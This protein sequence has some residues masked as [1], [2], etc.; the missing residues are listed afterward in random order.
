MKS[1][2]EWM[3]VRQ[4]YEAGASI[5]SIAR[6]MGMDRKTVRKHLSSEAPPSFSPRHAIL[7]PY[8]DY[9]VTRL[10]QYPLSAVRIHEDIAAMGYSGGYTQVKEFMR[11]VRR[12]RPVQ[13][14]IR[15]E[16]PPGE[17]AQADW[18]DFSSRQLGEEVVHLFAFVMVLGYS[19]MRFVEFTTS[20]DTPTFIKCHLHA[21]EHFGGWPRTILYDNSKNV[22][23][24]RALRTPDS[25]LNSL[26]LDF[27]QHHGI[28]PRLCKPGIAG[29]K[30]KGKV[31][32][33][34]QYVEDNFFLGREF[35]SLDELNSSAWEWCEKANAK[36]HGT[37]HEVP[38]ERLKLEGL[39]G[40]AS[41]VPYQ[42]VRREVRKV[43]RDCFLSYRGNRYSVPWQHAGRECRLAIYDDFFDVFVDEVAVARHGIVPG[44]H[45]CIA[46]KE[47]FEG[48]YGQKRKENELRHRARLD[49]GTEG[50]VLVPQP[51]EVA[52]RDLSCYERF[53]GGEDD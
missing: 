29:A 38:M 25:K 17:Q 31:E 34:I 18:I 39:K 46:R 35:G 40:V 26:Y 28:K 21:F 22:V 27:I 7:D 5:S 37:T 12:D 51:V 2:V 50:L 36:V 10:S 53:S 52:K 43:S 13:A 32:R 47:H 48:L 14:E 45:R 9:I 49:C 44:S 42:V 4:M 3:D 33:A 8:K 15:F 41:I 19:R 20:V 11:T 1:E 24:V 16:T 6:A 23:V 30:T